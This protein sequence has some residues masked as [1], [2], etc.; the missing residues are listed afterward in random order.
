MKK[1]CESC[2]AERPILCFFKKFGH[3]NPLFRLFSVLSKQTLQFLQQIYVKN[4]HP[5]YGAGIR[6]H[7][8]KETSLLPNHQTRAPVM[9]NNV[10][11]MTQC[12]FFF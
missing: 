6:N 9:F 3:P 12:F 5:V 2:L 8:L 1:S 10:V 7:N 4:I 11:G